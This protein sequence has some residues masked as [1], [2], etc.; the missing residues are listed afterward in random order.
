M[1]AITHM[2]NVLGTVQPIRDVVNIAH[3]NDIPVLIDGT[4]GAVHDT[5]DVDEVG[6]DFYVFTGHKLYGLR[7]LVFYTRRKSAK[8]I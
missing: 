5:I 6:V 8:R 2:S 1:I 4:Q 3:N 7:V